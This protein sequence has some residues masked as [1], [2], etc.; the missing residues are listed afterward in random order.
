MNFPRLD[1]IIGRKSVTFYRVSLEVFRNPKLW[2]SKPFTFKMNRSR[3]IR[4]MIRDT[5]W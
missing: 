3:Y 1:L 5:P 4:I 2:V